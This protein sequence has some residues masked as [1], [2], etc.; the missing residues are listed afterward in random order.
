MT[1]HH[2]A[3]MIARIHRWRGWRFAAD[4]CGIEQHIRALQ[5]H[6]AGAFRK[7]LIPADRRTKFAVT[8][9]PGFESGIARVKIEFLLVT[10]AVWNM[11]F[12]V[13]PEHLAVGIDHGE[14]VVMRITRPFEEAQGK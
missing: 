1:L 8:G 14:R 6:D 11:G 10:G 12:A 5:R 9:L 13:P 7:P 2:A 3:P 4:R